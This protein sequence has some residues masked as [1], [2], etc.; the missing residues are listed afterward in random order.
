V[1]AYLDR[2]EPLALQMCPAADRELLKTNLRAMRDSR[3]ITATKVDI[4]SQSGKPPAP[5]RQPADAEAALTAKRF[6]LIIERL[7]RQVGG[8]GGGPVPPQAVAQLV[9]LAAASAS[10][11]QELNEYMKRVKPI[12]GE[13]QD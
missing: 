9:S 5:M 7:S 11:E 3:S 1:L 2:V 4:S 6:S 13:Q 8:G 12:A 10:N